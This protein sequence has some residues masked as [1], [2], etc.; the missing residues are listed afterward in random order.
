[1]GTTG[2]TEK[3]VNTLDD[4]LGVFVEGVQNRMVTSHE[5][6][7][8]SSRSHAILTLRIVKKVCIYICMYVCVYT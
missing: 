2:L 3:S 7:S 6:N 1:M 4:L 5:M 8:E